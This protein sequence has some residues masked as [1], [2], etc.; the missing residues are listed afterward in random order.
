MPANKEPKSK[1]KIVEFFKG[2]GTFLLTIL[3]ANPSTIAV[4][5]TPGSPTNNGLF[6][7]LLH[8]IWAIRLTSSSLPIKVSILL[9]EALRFRLTQKLS[10]AVFS[11]TFDPVFCPGSKFSV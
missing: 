3:L 10:S 11:L 2:S 9:L 8:N 4:L 1:E 5:P 7:V 6:L